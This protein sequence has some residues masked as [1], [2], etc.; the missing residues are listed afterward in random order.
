M[1]LNYYEILNLDY[2]AN[3]KEIAESYLWQFNVALAKVDK[4]KNSPAEEFIKAYKTR[5]QAIDRLNEAYKVLS[6][7]EE[8]I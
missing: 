4:Y 5:M 1:N 2:Y 7:I 8:R 3:G 6:S